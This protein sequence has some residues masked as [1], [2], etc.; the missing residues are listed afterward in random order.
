MKEN[1]GG[2]LVLRSQLVAALGPG[3]LSGSRISERW[4]RIWAMWIQVK[5]EAWEDLLPLWLPAPLNR[6]AAR[7][8][9]L[10]DTAPPLGLTFFWLP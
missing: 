4:E 6:N 1:E 3:E 9:S 7:G 5:E 8:F 10:G 2:R